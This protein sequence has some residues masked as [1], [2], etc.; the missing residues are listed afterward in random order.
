MSNDRSNII[1]PLLAGLAVGAALGVL[2]APRPGSE[3]RAAIRRKAEEARDGLEDLVDE[4]RERFAEAKARTSGTASNAKG[5]A[6][7]FISFLFTEG[8]DLWQ[9]VKDDQRK[10][11]V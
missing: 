5:E 11:T 9:R 6:R 1:L 4:A 2:F 7:D 10:H 3:T 8:R